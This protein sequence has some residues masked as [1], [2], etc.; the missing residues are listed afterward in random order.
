MSY[1]RC[2]GNEAHGY[3]ALTR[4]C[5]NAHDFDR[6]YYRTFY[7]GEERVHGAK[8]IAHLARGV[9]GFAAWLGIDVRAVLDVGAGTGLWG[10][11]F[12]RYRPKVSFRSIDVSPHACRRF[13][14]ERRDIAS[15]QAR[16]SF[17]LVVCHSVLQYLD[18]AR[19][20]RAI[21]NIGAMC[22][23]LLYLE[24]IT[25]EDRAILDEASTDLR[26]HLR[27]ERWYRAR[28]RRWFVQV[29]AGLWAARRSGVRLYAL[30]GVPARGRGRR[31][32]RAD[33]ADA[34]RHPSA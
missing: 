18:D 28:L 16:R 10:R 26:I 21:G 31:R 34:R 29:G 30:E 22:R 2:S 8:E 7:S 17:D 23:G 20:E 12:Q 15:W 33:H 27:P 9:C 11:W 32:G 14:H 25:S 24:A 5:M 6:E 1:L 13:G 19:A 3:H 4:P